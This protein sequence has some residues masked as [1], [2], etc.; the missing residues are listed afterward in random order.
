M[1]CYFCGTESVGQCKV[2]GRFACERHSTIIDNRFV[3]IECEI[4]PTSA[5]LEM[6]KDLLKRSEVGSCAICG[7][8]VIDWDTA[9]RLA[10]DRL[11]TS[12]FT[13]S[14]E[15]TRQDWERL[16]IHRSSII[17]CPNGCVLC[18]NH[19]PK[20]ALFGAWKCL[21]CGKR[22]RLKADR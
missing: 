8:R 17:L 9:N 13:L 2:D 18:Y 22:F 3:C 10:G 14:S 4:G 6:A 1:G 16:T 19:S 5:R 7:V 15:L 12:I 21:S 11:Y 20:E